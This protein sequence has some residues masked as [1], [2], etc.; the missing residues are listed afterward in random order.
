M[1]HGPSPALI[2]SPMLFSCFCG[3][4][5]ALLIPCRTSWHIARVRYDCLNESSV[6]NKKWYEEE[7]VEQQYR[8]SRPSSR[9]YREVW[10]GIDEVVYCDHSCHHICAVTNETDEDD[11]YNSCDPFVYGFLVT[12]RHDRL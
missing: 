9:L 12:S 6:A 10:R 11:R 8:R 4:F 7:I 1:W 3:L 5:L 2:A